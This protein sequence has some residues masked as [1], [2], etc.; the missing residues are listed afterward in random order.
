VKGI[1]DK[2]G[3]TL[4]DHDAE[5]LRQAVATRKTNAAK[6][7]MT[8]RISDS[9]LGDEEMV[10]RN[11]SDQE[12][13]PVSPVS[14]HVTADASAAPELKLQALVLSADPEAGEPLAS[15]QSFTAPTSTATTSA[16]S[17]TNSDS[18]QPTSEQ[19]SDTKREPA[20]DVDSADGSE[21][22]STETTDALSETAPQPAT[23]GVDRE[24]PQH[25]K[26]ADS[27]NEDDRHS[28][29]DDEED[30]RGETPRQ[31]PDNVSHTPEGK[32]THKGKKE[33]DDEDGSATEG[34][35]EED[36][37]LETPRTEDRALHQKPASA[38]EG[39]GVGN[40]DDDH[41]ITEG[42][43]E[44]DIRGELSPRGQT[45]RKLPLE[46]V[47]GRSKS[48]GKGKKDDEGDDEP[49]EGEDEE[50]IRGETPR[51]KETNA[52]LVKGIS[53][54]GST[55]SKF[56]DSDDDTLTEGDDEQDIRG[57]DDEPL[58]VDVH[59]AAVA[60]MEKS[61]TKEERKKK[62]KSSR[63]KKS[64]KKQPE[65][66]RDEEKVITQEQQK[67]EEG[68]S[69]R[70]IVRNI[71]LKLIG[72][73]ATIERDTSPKEKKNKKTKGLKKS[74]TLTAS[75]RISR[76][77]PSAESDERRGKASADS[78]SSVKT[79]SG[80]LSG[81]AVASVADDEDSGQWTAATAA[82]P[83][84]RRSRGFLSGR[85]EATS[86]N[87]AG[88]DGENSKKKKKEHRKSR[89]KLSIRRSVSCE[90]SVGHLDEPAGGDEGGGGLKVQIRHSQEVE[91]KRKS[92]EVA[93]KR[94]SKE[95]DNNGAGRERRA[96][97]G[98]A[99]KA[100]ERRSKE[101]HMSELEKVANDKADDVSEDAPTSDKPNS[102]SPFK[103]FHTI[104]RAHRKR[105]KTI[106]SG[107][108]YPPPLSIMLRFVSMNS[109]L[110]LSFPLDN[111]RSAIRWKLCP[112]SRNGFRSAPP[113]TVS[114][115]PIAL[116]PISLK[117]QTLDQRCTSHLRVSLW[118]TTR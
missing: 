59:L 106:N 28:D 57:E 110:T 47:A 11:C 99:E 58:W 45:P 60:Q 84:R 69:A 19:A 102:P 10:G 71:S 68:N 115:R 114:R 98:F 66:K 61:T 35:D 92:R 113:S 85:I 107:G 65:P 88:E 41:A 3:K 18:T 7:Q 12:T 34:E 116:V 50:D 49:T 91:T 17:K 8:R 77:R 29:G 56:S 1:W 95:V 44:E 63:E 40:D 79:A 23:Q 2:R 103:K 43:D 70:R 100:I 55:I 72:K 89:E 52:D 62:K 21:E 78:L 53:L 105:N 38:K 93:E 24:T 30:I 83:V 109:S 42:E 67:K 94:A 31:R 81:D 101:L 26:G 48:E 82:S 87:A 97:G 25:Q 16:A 37:R 51:G 46:A 112:R 118:L 14:T 36:I 15:S 39:D 117:V 96:S 6:S 13:S 33:A 32:E 75:P 5:T 9:Q 76:D 20:D 80:S 104:G 74:N 111:Q 86:D 73:S 22:A 90:P 108:T 54:S 27:D 64:K 4:S